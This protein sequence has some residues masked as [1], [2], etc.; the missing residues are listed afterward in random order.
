MK[1]ILCLTFLFMY[2]A[3][4]V[5]ASDI[6]FVQV[7]NLQYSPNSTSSV[8]DFANIIDEINKIKDVDFVIFSGNNI[9]KSDKKY[10]DSFLKKAKKLN[11][12][13]YIALGHKDLNKKKGLSKTAYIEIVRKNT[14]KN[15]QETNYTFSK[16]GVVFI[17]ADGAKEF[18]AT[19]FGY[20]RESA[21]DYVDKALT[22][23]SK[24]NAVILQHFPIYPPN[25]NEEFRTYNV[26]EYI[27]ML[28]KHTNVKAVISGFNVNSENDIAGVK[29]ITTASFPKYRIIEIIEPKSEN[30]TIWTTLK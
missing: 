5:F 3:I 13:C 26:Q 2:S 25:S 7:D 8:Q 29:Y 20:Y 1:K 9:A 15:I 21:I 28:N 30:P 17:V 12:P 4:S 16:K 22:K 10:L 14:Y 27:K 18:I 19:P 24:K 23:Y 6:K 11:C